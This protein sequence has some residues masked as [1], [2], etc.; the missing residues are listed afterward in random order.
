MVITVHFLQKEDADQLCSELTSAQKCSQFSRLEVQ[1][2]VQYTTEVFVPFL[3][4]ITPQIIDLPF[5]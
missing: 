4:L 1:F 5:L 2:T 3:S